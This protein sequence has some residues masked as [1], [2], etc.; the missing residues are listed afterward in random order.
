MAHDATI[1][2]LDANGLRNFGISTGAIVAGLFGLLLPWLFERALPL[3]PWAVFAVLAAWALL[4]PR[5]LR[6]VYRYWMK[7]G[8]LLNRVTTPIVLG[9]VFFL[10]VAPM[11]L[12]RRAFGR[13]AMA[14][15]FDD[16]APTY[17][18]KSRDNDNKLENPY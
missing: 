15:T 8:L 2:E 5:S 18:V 13:D 10:V 4:A 11:G 1:P 6:L 9:V 7:L 16:A 3:W 17:R 14:R 12:V